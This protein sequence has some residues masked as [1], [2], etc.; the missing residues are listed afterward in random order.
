VQSN[1][2]V[3]PRRPDTRARGG[4]A[5]G[6]R[7]PIDIRRFPWIRRLAADYVFDHARVADFF[8][9]NPDDPAAWRDAIARTHQHHRQRDA[10][11]D[12]VQAQ[13]RAR[14]ASDAAISATALLR[15][16][17][18]VAVVTGQQ[19][20]LFGGPLFTLLKALT[21][22]DSPSRYEPS[23]ACRRSPVFWIDAEDHDWDEV[24][25]CSV[26]DADMKPLAIAP[27]I[28]RRRTPVR[29]PASVST[30]R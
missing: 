13:Q 10:I 16:P 1:Q 30:S 12:L 3:C 21:R 14:G 25:S 19:A 9:G 23:T 27:A 7:L 11:A 29:S 18:T 24:K 22:F 4:D 20:G 2:V 28:R 8:A 26:L 15:N 5:A 17:Q 6:S